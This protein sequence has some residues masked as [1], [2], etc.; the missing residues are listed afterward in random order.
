MASYVAIYH[1]K[2][3]KLPFLPKKTY[4]PRH[5]KFTKDTLEEAWQEAV[6]LGNTAGNIDKVELYKLVLE[7][8]YEENQ[9]RSGKR[10]R[11]EPERKVESPILFPSP[12]FQIKPA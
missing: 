3:I 2:S 1:F 10:K 5:V 11:A 6:I 12:V 4:G 9:R 8:T 7:E